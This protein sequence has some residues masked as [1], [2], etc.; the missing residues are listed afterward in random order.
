MSKSKKRNDDTAEQKVAIFRK[1]L[2]EGTCV[3]DVCEEFNVK[4]C[5]Y[6]SWQK[7]F[8]E[9]GVAAFQRFLSEGRTLSSPVP[10]TD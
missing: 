5:L 1:H 7:K 8:F 3:Y 9:S 10:S 4:P 6:D 2:V